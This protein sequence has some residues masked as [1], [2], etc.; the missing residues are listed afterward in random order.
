MATIVQVRLPL[1][2]LLL[3]CAGGGIKSEWNGYFSSYILSSLLYIWVSLSKFDMCRGSV[4][5]L[6]IAVFC[7]RDVQMVIMADAGA[8]MVVMYSESGG[9]KVISSW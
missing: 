9:D 4:N 5:C 7:T 8:V 6:P 1:T 2:S 3:Y